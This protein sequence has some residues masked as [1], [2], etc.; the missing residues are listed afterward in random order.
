VENYTG[1]QYTTGEELSAKFQNH[2]ESFNF[3]LKLEKVN[4]VT[5]D[6][7][8]FR[9]HT[10]TTAYNGRTVI[11]ATGRT[12]REL[13]GSGEKAL[14]N[15]GVTYCATCDALLFSDLDIAV[16]GGGNSGLEAVL[17]LVNIAKSIHL[18]ELMP[19]LSADK[20]L[21]EKARASDKVE[22]R[23]HTR[24]TAIVGQK[25]VE[26]L[27]ISKDG[28]EE[29]LPVQGVFVEIGSVPNSEMVDF[30]RAC[31]L[32]RSWW[33]QEKAVKPHYQPSNTFIEDLPEPYRYRVFR[34]IVIP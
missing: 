21:I 13:N 6:D 25:V 28:K 24:V 16:V 8:Q 11:I 29:R 12:P 7:G 14:K 33:L 23:T 5:R 2:L 3:D 10:D 19:S 20:I 1:Y 4:K 26:G 15:R 30:S 31:L 18:I 9:V 17:Q 22:I 32:N 27:M 34:V